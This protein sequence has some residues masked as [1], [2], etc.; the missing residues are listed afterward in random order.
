M[1]DIARREFSSPGTTDPDR[2]AIDPLF[3]LEMSFHPSWLTDIRFASLVL[4]SG[5]LHT[6][7]DECLHQGA[8]SDLVPAGFVV[9]STHSKR[10]QPEA[11]VASAPDAHILLYR[12]NLTKVWVRVAAP[13]EREVEQWKSLIDD[14]GRIA[15]VP[16]TIPATFWAL[17]RNGP[18]ST[19][20]SI[21]AVA[22]SDI[23]RNY[24]ASTREHLEELA[25]FGTQRNRGG[26]IIWFGPA[27]TGKTTAV[28]SMAT[29]WQE[30]REL[31]VVTDI[32]KLLHDADYLAQVTRPTVPSNG[33]D[34]RAKLIVAEDVDPLL[35][36]EQ[37]LGGSGSLARLLGLTDG[38]LASATDAIV[39]VTTNA[40]R[41]Q[42]APSLQRPGRCL[43][44]IEFG[45]LSVNDANDWLRPDVARV[46]EP[47]TL[48]ELYHRAG[49]VDRIGA[50]DTTST[51]VGTYL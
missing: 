17:G 4:D 46:T 11:L 3:R 18:S 37:Q 35:L 33:G 41:H 50:T 5:F 44:L 9:Q 22:C 19:H 10:G 27:G 13:S 20:R 47:A 36:A 34:V 42:I 40:R 45:P 29:A 21:E 43:A 7:V 39:L 32:E 8:L 23:S 6:G 2:G 24:D 16:D 14:L 25:A 49:L 12:E 30:D 31:N 48:A 51:R 15:E 26:L 28:R 38:L 1:T